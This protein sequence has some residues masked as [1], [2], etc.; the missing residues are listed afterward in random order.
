MLESTTPAVNH[1]TDTVFDE[2]DKVQRR[3]L[4]ACG[5]TDE[6]ALLYYTL[7]PYKQGAT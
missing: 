2:L 3:L 5:L 4:K 7:L 1:C 6:Q